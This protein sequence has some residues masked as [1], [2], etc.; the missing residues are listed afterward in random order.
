LE[1]IIRRLISFMR[2]ELDKR[3]ITVNHNLNGRSLKLFA[4]QELLYRAFL[5][6]LINAMESMEDGGGFIIRAER[7]RD[8]YIIEFEDTGCGIS[9]ENINRVLKPF[10]TTKNK[11]NGLGLSIVKKIVEAHSGTVDIYSR[12]GEGTKIMVRLPRTQGRTA[13][14]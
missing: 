7:E 3:G 8:I 9:E 2:P 11:G 4:D 14:R 1:E 13:G 6:I 5:N 10:F 12:E